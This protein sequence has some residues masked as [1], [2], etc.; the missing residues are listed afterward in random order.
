MNNESIKQQS[1]NIKKVK[2]IHIGDTTIM[3]TDTQPSKNILSFQ[4]L[5]HIRF[6]KDDIKLIGVSLV[7]ILIFNAMLVGISLLMTHLSNI[8]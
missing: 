4:C 2:T 8:Q 5:K 1:S 6:N 7:Y 3:I